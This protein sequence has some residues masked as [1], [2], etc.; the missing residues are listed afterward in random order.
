MQSWIPSVWSK[1]KVYAALL[2][3]NAD[4]PLYS[5]QVVQSNGAMSSEANPFFIALSN[6]LIG[7]KIVGTQEPSA[8]ASSPKPLRDDS[9]QEK[10]EYIPLTP[11]G[12]PRIEEAPKTPVVQPWS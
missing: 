10:W 6:L 9:P 12:S 3:A 2:Q 4:H 5:I 11:S 8:V 7:D 1:E